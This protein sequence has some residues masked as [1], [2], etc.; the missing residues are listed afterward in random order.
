MFNMHIGFDGR[1]SYAKGKLDA[2]GNELTREEIPGNNNLILNAGLQYMAFNQGWLRYLHLGSGVQEPAPNQ[3]ILQN[4]TYTGENASPNGDQAYGINVTD[5]NKPYHWFRRVFRVAPVGSNR[6]YSE[7]GVGWSA[8]N[9]FSR[10]LIKDPLGNP[11]TI[12][13]LGDEY[14]DVTYEIRMY[15]PAGDRVSVIQPTGDDL[16]P[17]TVTVRA[18][19]AGVRSIENDGWEISSHMRYGSALL[20]DYRSDAHN[21]F[22]NGVLGN[23]YEYGGG[24]QVGITFNA[25]SGVRTSDTSYTFNF[26]RDLHHNVGTLSFIALSQQGYAFQVQ[27]DPPFVKDNESRFWFSYSISWGRVGE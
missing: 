3:T 8:T 26:V 16:E 2:D 12:T 9:L 23:I 13:V 7:V 1:F 21:L 11:N 17:R 5:P 14:L 24:N 10:A 18:R 22:G 4:T 25:S 27:I 20:T 19:R 6:T 15:I